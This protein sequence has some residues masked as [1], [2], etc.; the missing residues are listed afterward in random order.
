MLCLWRVD[1]DILESLPPLKG[2]FQSDQTALAGMIFAIEGQVSPTFPGTVEKLQIF[3]QTKES[4][5]AIG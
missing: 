4:F 3:L 1:H 5:P 2:S